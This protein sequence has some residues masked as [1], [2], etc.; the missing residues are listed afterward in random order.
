EFSPSIYTS[1]GWNIAGGK[2]ITTDG[3]LEYLLDFNLKISSDP[4]FGYDGGLLCADFQFRRGGF[5]SHEA[6]SYQY[7]TYIE[8][9]NLCQLFELWYMQSFSKDRYWI[10]IGKM[11]CSEIIDYS[12][13]AQNYQYQSFENIPTIRNVPYFPDS[14]MGVTVYL[15]PVDWFSLSAGLLDGSAVMGVNTGNIGVFGEFFNDLAH[16][17]FMF[18]EVDFSWLKDKSHFGR[19]GVG[20]WRNT[21]TVKKF[22]GGTAQGMQGMYL[23]LDQTIWKPQDSSDPRSVGFFTQTG[24]T[25]PN[26]SHIKQLYACGVNWTG[27]LPQR[28]ADQFGV[29]FCMSRFSLVPGSGFV[30]PTESVFETYYIYSPYEWIDIQPDIQYIITPGGSGIPYALVALFNINMTF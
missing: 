25:N 29:G 20:A 22:S 9:R 1:T 2:R 23:L 16:H 11:D 24:F 5:P 18:G 8:A 26:T 28:S 6:G 30:K 17:A 3:N 21:S 13:Y 12:I 4:L 14:A 15:N 19:I 27:I 10:K 7:L